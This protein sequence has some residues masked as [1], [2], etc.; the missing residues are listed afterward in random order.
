MFLSMTTNVALCRG[1]S[2]VTLFHFVVLPVASRDG[3]QKN[4]HSL[5]RQNLAGL[6]ERV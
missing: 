1:L 2:R 6:A 3:S 4:W 5:G